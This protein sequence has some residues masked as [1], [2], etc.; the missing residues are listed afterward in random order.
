M[1]PLWPWIRGDETE[2]PESSLFLF[3]PPTAREAIRL[4]IHLLS[5]QRRRLWR[6]TGAYEEFGFGELADGSLRLVKAVE[7]EIEFLQS[8]SELARPDPAA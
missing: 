6:A 2:L 8:S 3:P 4:E 7:E 5:V 1:D